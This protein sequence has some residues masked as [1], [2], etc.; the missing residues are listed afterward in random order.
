MIR[1]ENP[2]LREVK[3][4]IKLSIPLIIGLAAATLIGV[5]DTIMIAPLGTVPL[6]AAGITT[7]FLIILISALWGLLTVAS[8]R[9]SQ[10]HGRGD[11]ARVATELRAALA[12][13]CL[14]GICAMALMLL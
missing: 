11:D 14:A 12:G 2:T 5:V 10:A 4:L 9:I 1:H 6:A 8:V 13:G 7:A 3:P